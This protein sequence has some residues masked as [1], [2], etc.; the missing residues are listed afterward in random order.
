LDPR[1]R[2]GPDLAVRDGGGEELLWL[3]HDVDR[4][5]GNHGMLRIRAKTLAGASR[6]PKTKVNRDVPVVTLACS[7]P[8]DGRE[9][10]TLQLLADV[11]EP[12]PP[13]P[14]VVRRQDHEYKRNGTANVFVAFERERNRARA[15]VN[16]RFTTDDA[17]IELNRLYPT[18]E[19]W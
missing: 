18:T 9:S 12:L 3:T 7:A 11:R 14:G 15:G 19:L 2:V 8:P 17:R 6:Q 16:R 4:G 1:Q 13:A 10:W 5:V